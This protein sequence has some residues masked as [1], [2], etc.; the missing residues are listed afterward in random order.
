MDIQKTGSSATRTSVA[1]DSDAPESGAADTRLNYTLPDPGGDL[2]GNPEL[3]VPNWTVSNP[4]SD[5]VNKN[6]SMQF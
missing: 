1:P 3:K 4:N 6:S 5:P 2:R